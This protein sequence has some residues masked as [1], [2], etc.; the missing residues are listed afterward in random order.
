M[1]GKE[2]RLLPV[3]ITRYAHEKSSALL[4]A[5]RQGVAESI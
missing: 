5:G 4:P 3:V 1:I 2:S